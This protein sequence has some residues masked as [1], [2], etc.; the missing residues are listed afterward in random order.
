MYIF[1]DHE[2]RYKTYSMY[3]YIKLVNLMYILY[4]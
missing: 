4:L 3:I 2:V 1:A